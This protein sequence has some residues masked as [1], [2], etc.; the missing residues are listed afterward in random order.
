MFMKW[1]L[2]RQAKAASHTFFPLPFLPPPPPPAHA[3]Q[4]APQM[5]SV[6]NQRA[7]VAAR[8]SAAAPAARRGAVQ[9]CG[10]EAER[11]LGD[12]VERNGR[13]ALPGPICGLARRRLV[14][15]WRAC[16]HRVGVG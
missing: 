4:H 14:P 12:R 3:P 16:P 1:G 11:E 5:Q 7:L 15:G 2:L 13:G 8:P 9:V 10:R 6:L